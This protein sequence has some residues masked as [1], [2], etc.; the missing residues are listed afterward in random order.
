VI[1]ESF[2]NLLWRK[3]LGKS[4]DENDKK[5]TQLEKFL[6]KLIREITKKGVFSFTAE[7]QGKIPGYKK[8]WNDDWTVLFTETL[9][10]NIIKK[11]D[12]KKDEY[13]DKGFYVSRP[14]SELTGEWMNVFFDD[15]Q[16]GK[17]LIYKFEVEPL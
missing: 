4:S 7:A 3:L 8:R 5:D 9:L 16:N 10:P 1:H 2:S 13:D 15:L 12:W 11:I 6:K 14:I 17:F